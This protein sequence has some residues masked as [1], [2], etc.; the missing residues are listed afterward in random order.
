[1]MQINGAARR[2]FRERAGP[3]R[4][5]VS[6][7]GLVWTASPSL[8]LASMGLRLVRAL[9]PVL[10]LYVGKLII[11]AVVAQTRL[12]SPGDDLSTW[13][14]SGRLDR[15]AFLLGVEFGLA[16]LSNGLGR[17]SSL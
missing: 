10:S 8:T 3:F 12:V 16:I 5:L 15:L 2:M 4:H 9:L 7:F 13:L 1:M 14:M 11:D 6:L 17:A